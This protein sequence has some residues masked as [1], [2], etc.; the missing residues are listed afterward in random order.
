MVLNITMC[1]A[2]C[3]FSVSLKKKLIAIHQMDFANTHGLHLATLKKK[4]LKM[5]ILWD[6]EERTMPSIQED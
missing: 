1:G 3:Y 6:K 4:F 2:L 5:L